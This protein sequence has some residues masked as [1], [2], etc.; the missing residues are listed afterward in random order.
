MPFLFVTSSLISFISVLQFS[1]YS[2][3]AFLGRFVC[4]HAC[5][6]VSDCLHLWSVACQASMS[7]GFSKQEYWSGLPFP[8][9]RDLPDS[10]IES[11][12]PTSPILQVDSAP[13]SHR[14]SPSISIGPDKKTGNYSK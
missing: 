4:M 5:P 2:S 12:S 14:G 9:P 10:E 6:V 1:E 7:I 11:V 3:Q 8:L 13:L